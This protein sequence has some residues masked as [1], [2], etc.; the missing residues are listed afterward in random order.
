[1][2]KNMNKGQRK[3]GKIFASHITEKRL[4]SLMF[5]MLL[6]IHKKKTKVCKGSEQEKE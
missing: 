6:E 4:N 3:L 5:E 1:M 2:E